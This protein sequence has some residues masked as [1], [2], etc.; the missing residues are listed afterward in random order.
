MIRTSVRQL[1]VWTL[2]AAAAAV[3]VVAQGNGNG[4]GKDKDKP[5]TPVFEAP[6]E[7]TAGG[8]PLRGILYPSP[9]LHDSDGDQR[10][11]L[12]VGDLRGHIQ[13]AKPSGQPSSTSWGELEFLQAKNKKRL[14]LNNW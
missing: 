1:G 6:V 13:I 12:W 10:P 5:S 4:N 14:K 7:L 8:K 3:P 9:T 11:E 2:A